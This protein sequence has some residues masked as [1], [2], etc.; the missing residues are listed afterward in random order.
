MLAT[1]LAGQRINAPQP[2]PTSP[3]A[4]PSTPPT[5]GS[6]AAEL[7]AELRGGPASRGACA[8]ANDAPVHCGD[9]V[10]TQAVSPSCV[11]SAPAAAP[12]WRPWQNPDW[13]S[14]ISA[15]S[16]PSANKTNL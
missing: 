9:S 12:L 5:D 15:C 1:L 14:G 8:P 4:G 3:G 2:E 13:H 16:G 11:A 6:K 7:A 10:K